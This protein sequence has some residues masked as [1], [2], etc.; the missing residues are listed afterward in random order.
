MPLCYCRVHERVFI[1]KQQRWINFSYERIHPLTNAFQLYRT[2]GA[3]APS[4]EVIET[5]CDQCAET[6]QQK[7]RVLFHTHDLL[8]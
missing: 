1:Q 8:S 6:A 2:F 3:D 4:Y 5:A 7:L